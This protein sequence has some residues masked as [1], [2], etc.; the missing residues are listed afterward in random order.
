MCKELEELH[1]RVTKID[2]FIKN[3]PIYKE[4]TPQQKDLMWVQRNAM[5]VYEWALRERLTIEK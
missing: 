1:D 5:Q 4:L 3:N 2:D